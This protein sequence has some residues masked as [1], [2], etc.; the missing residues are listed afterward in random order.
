[1][2]ERFCRILWSPSLSGK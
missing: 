2:I 1:M